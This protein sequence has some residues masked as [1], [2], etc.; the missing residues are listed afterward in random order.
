M[1][2][3]EA[4]RKAEKAG[5]WSIV[6]HEPTSIEIYF[7]NDDGREDSTQFD[8]YADDKITEAEELYQT[9]CRENNFPEDTVTAVEAYGYIVD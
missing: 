3:R 5:E 1:K 2:I 8:L 6:L 4:I 9:F 7:I